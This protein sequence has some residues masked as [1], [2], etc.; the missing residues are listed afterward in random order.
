M[1]IRDST[2]YVHNFDISVPRGQ[3]KPRFIA[4]TLDSWL[5][6]MST[7]SRYDAP[8]GRRFWLTFK[9][10]TYYD[11]EEGTQVRP[12]FSSRAF[13]HRLIGALG[14]SRAANIPASSRG[15]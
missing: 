3:Y 5:G 4:R 12:R 15:P 7:L 6:N 8:H 1:C 14:V 10:T 9:G 11:G 2:N 13:L